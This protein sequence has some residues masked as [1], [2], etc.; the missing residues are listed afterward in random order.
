M[1]LNYC[2]Q[3]SIKIPG[4]KSY[5]HFAHF[6]MKN[7]EN[8]L[9][10]YINYSFHGYS[11]CRV[12]NT[13]S[14]SCSREKSEIAFFWI[15]IIFFIIKICILQNHIA[16]PTEKNLKFFFSVSLVSASIKNTRNI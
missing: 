10:I 13:K 9:Q 2:N 7:K 1:L 15:L 3:S 5:F 11:L 16:E 14:N 8:K 4:K 12:Y 6:P